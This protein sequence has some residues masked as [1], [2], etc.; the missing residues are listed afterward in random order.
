M[1]TKNSLKG[2]I[3][4]LLIEDKRYC[5]PNFSAQQLAE[6]LGVSP[7]QLSRILKSEYGMSYMGV[8]HAHRIQSA[9]HHLKDRRLASYSVD[10][11]GAL[12]GFRNRQSFFGAFK[13]LTGTTPDIYR[14]MNTNGT[15]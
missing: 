2:L 14:R 13:K 9:M 3:D 5:D 15:D 6:M 10:D 1:N 8:V 12:V 4:R 7:S 11:I